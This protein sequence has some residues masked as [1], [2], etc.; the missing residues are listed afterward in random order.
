MCCD[1]WGSQRKALATHWV[2]VYFVCW[3]FDFLFF[4]HCR[5]GLNW[6]PY[7]LTSSSSKLCECSVLQIYKEIF[8]LS[9]NIFPNHFGPHFQFFSFIFFFLPCPF[10]SCL[11]ASSYSSPVFLSYTY[12]LSLSFNS[13]PL[14]LCSYSYLLFLHSCSSCLIN[15]FILSF[16]SELCLLPPAQ[17]SCWNVEIVCRRCKQ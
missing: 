5:W 11:P 1:I 7:C 14:S 8:C 12:I 9:H 2:S 10:L 17:F 16:L 4:F 6:A 13:F 15:F 3:W